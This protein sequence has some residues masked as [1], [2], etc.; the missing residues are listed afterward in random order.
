MD[1]TENNAILGDSELGGVW[2][3]QEGILL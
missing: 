3:S 2:I 1:G